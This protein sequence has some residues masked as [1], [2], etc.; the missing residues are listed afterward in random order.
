MIR[1]TIEVDQYD[2]RFTVQREHA[3][4]APGAT[5]VVDALL[6]E[7]RASMHAALT[8]VPSRATWDDVKL[9]P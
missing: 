4:P 2:H 7:A 6:G 9:R 3:D 8:A 5:V 1:V